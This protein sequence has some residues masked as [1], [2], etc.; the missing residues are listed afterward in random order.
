M[1]KQDLQL[2]YKKM[3]YSFVRC[4]TFSSS[5]TF[6]VSTQKRWVLM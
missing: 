2:K 6:L 5:I 4:Y 3:D 1:E